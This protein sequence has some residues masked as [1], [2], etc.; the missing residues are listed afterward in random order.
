MAIRNDN[1]LNSFDQEQ[2][3]C[4]SETLYSANGTPLISCWEMEDADRCGYVHNWVVRIVE[5]HYGGGTDPNPIVEFYSI[6]SNQFVSSYYCDTLLDSP[7]DHSNGLDL[8][9]DVP[10][11]KI[12]G[13]DYPTILVWIEEALNSR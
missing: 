11:W 3:R 2:F 6:D 4:V 13:Q 7:N 1:L 8:W 10:T 12:S 9:G 5:S